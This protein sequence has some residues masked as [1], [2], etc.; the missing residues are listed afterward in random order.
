MFQFSVK[1]LLYLVKHSRPDI[2]KATHE[3]SKN[4][5]RASKAQC[6]R[7]H[8]AFKYIHD[9][10]NLGLKIEPTRDGEEQWNII[11]F[12]DKNCVSDQEMKQSVGGFILYF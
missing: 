2:V 11:Y 1:M 5:D 6:L 12:N 4:N 7:M 10:R 8:C 3:L 9:M